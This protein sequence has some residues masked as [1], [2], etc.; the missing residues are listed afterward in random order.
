MPLYIVMRCLKDGTIHD[1]WNGGPLPFT[2]I[3]FLVQQGG[4][5]LHMTTGSGSISRSRGGDSPRSSSTFWPG[6]PEIARSQ[7]SGGASDL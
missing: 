7:A 2:A 4:Q 6:L 1:V 3:A 5:A